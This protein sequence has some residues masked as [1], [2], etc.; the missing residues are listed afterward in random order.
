MK[1]LK[2]FLAVGTVF[3]L[4]NESIYGARVN[5]K[6]TPMSESLAAH[7]IGDE[8]VVK[9]MRVN[10]ETHD[11]TQ[12]EKKEDTIKIEPKVSEVKPVLAEIKKEQENKPE[13]VNS[14]VSTNSTIIVNPSPISVMSPEPSQGKPSGV[15]PEEKSTDIKTVEI[16]KP[17]ESPAEPTKSTVSPVEP[18]KPTASPADVTKSTV[19][20]V[21]PQ[22]TSA[23][24]V[25]PQK[26]AV[27]PVEPQKEERKAVLKR[28]KQQLP[29]EKK[30][31]ATLYKVSAF[32]L[33]TI[34]FLLF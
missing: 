7:P 25:E 13:V 12:S 28:S 22:K 23:S 18:Q 1:F 16:S 4:L 24:S 30:N 29:E 34:S 5:L 14:T 9:Q 31:S 33:A 11:I 2:S 26:S 27:S 6:N 15:K 32:A 19:S 17:V 8:K 21:E 10:N 3:G 20:P